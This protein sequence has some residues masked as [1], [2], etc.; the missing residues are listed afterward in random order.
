MLI[1]KN[2]QIEYESAARVLGSTIHANERLTYTVVGPPAWYPRV[3][4]SGYHVHLIDFADKLTVADAM[5]PAFEIPTGTTHTYVLTEKQPFAFGA[6]NKIRGLLARYY[7]LDRRRELMGKVEAWMRIYDR[8]HTD[9][10]VH[11][12]DDAIRVWYIRQ[13]VEPEYAKRF[14]LAGS[15]SSS[16]MR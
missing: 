15:R 3:L 12:E 14:N 16:P 10:R 13:A 5:D 1:A 6:R 9:V 11:Y 4:G 7:D 2:S 8:F